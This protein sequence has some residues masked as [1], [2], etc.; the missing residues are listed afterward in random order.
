MYFKG[1]M[2]HLQVKF[3]LHLKDNTYLEL[4]SK[5]KGLKMDFCGKITTISCQIYI[6]DCNH[7]HVSNSLIF[8]PFY[9]MVARFVLHKDLISLILAIT[10]SGLLM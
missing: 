6:S 9:W 2:S 3:Q 4:P 10:C 5:Q 7:L 1:T 8:R